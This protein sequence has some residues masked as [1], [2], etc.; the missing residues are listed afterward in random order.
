[1]I[2]CVTLHSNM[3][4][5][6]RWVYTYSAKYCNF[7]SQTTHMHTSHTLW[8]VYGDC[9]AHIT[10][11]SGRHT[12]THTCAQLSFCVFAYAHLFV[13]Q[14]PKSNVVCVCV[15]V[16]FSKEPEFS[17]WGGQETDAHLWGPDWLTAL[18]HQSLCKHLWLRQQG[19]HKD[20]HPLMRTH[21][22]THKCI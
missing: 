7:F 18:C 9:K 21:T 5:C 12:H 13:E 10:H 15:C 20:T 1:M 14:S 19:T 16:W 11:S 8:M 2:V 22:H 3:H 4:R 17:W 6:G